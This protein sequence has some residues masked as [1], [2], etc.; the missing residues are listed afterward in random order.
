LA[1]LTKKNGSWGVDKVFPE[2]KSLRIDLK[3]CKSV[4]KG[5]WLALGSTSV[6]VIGRKKNS[7]HI[8][9]FYEIEGGY[10]ETNCFVPVALGQ[11]TVDRGGKSFLYSR[12]LHRYC[13]MPRHGNVF[14]DAFR[15]SRR[16]Q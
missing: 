11:L 6:R 9:E 12:N 7:C 3:S 13:R 8:Q 14:L 4:S 1:L 2:D 5:S 16:K 10:Y 15:R